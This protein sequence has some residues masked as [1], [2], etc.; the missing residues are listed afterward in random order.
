MIA[1]VISR[2]R[3]TLLKQT[4]DY[5]FKHDVITPVIV[6][7]GS[8]YAPL[9]RYLENAPCR[10]EFLARNHGSRVLWNSDLLDEYV[11]SSGEYIVTD[12]DLDMSGVPND[13]LDELREGLRRHDVPKA[14]IGLRID[15]L[16]DTDVARQVCEW[17]APHWAHPLDGGRFYEAS[18][19]TTLCLCRNREHT[20]K[21]VRTGPPYVARHVPWYYTSAADLPEDELYYMQ[22]VHPEK[23]NYWTIRLRRELN[24]KP[25]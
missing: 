3:L 24:V 25:L 5:L 17:E 1:F 11:P 6:D 19:L 9:L 12:P 7:N 10:V 16:P 15:D 14:G 4:M 13:W 23:W 20:F 2:N 18:T 22:T 8:T 21:S